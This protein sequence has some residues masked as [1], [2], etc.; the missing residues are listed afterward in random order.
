M[1]DSYRFVTTA[2]SG[3]RSG[4][5]HGLLGSARVAGGFAAMDQNISI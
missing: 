4:G 1:C 3:T 2:S 5:A